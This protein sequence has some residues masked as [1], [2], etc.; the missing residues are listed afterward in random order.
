LKTGITFKDVAF[1]YPTA[2]ENHPD[3]FKGVSFTIKAGTS[4]AIVGPS[5]AGKSTIV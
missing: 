1:R 2:S 4:T 5:G 3:T